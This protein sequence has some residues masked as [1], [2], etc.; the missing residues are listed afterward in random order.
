MG[1]WV[2]MA[3][4]ITMHASLDVDAL[5]AGDGWTRRAA[6]LVAACLGALVYSAPTVYEAGIRYFRGHR[7]KAVG[8]VV[9]TE[10]LMTFSPLWPLSVAALAILATINAIQTA[11]SA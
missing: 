4:W 10:I 9:L 6:I 1:L 3:T 7:A 8:F 2:P 5:V 11:R